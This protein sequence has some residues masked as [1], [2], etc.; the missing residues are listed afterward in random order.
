MVFMAAR[1][2]GTITPNNSTNSISDIQNT[3]RAIL[4]DCY[5]CSFHSYIGIDILLND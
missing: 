5:N 2:V 3:Y 4:I 1:S